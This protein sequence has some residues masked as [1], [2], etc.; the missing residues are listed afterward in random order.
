MIT[1]SGDVRLLDFGT[2]S[3]SVRQAAPHE[4]AHGNAQRGSTALTPA[5]AS[6]ELLEG[7]P[8]DP[9]DDLFA[10]ACLTYELLTGKH[11]FGQ[12]R[13]T[14]ARNLR[15]AVVRPSGLSQKQWNTLELGL[16]WSRTDRSMSISDW[17]AALNEEPAIQGVVTGAPA[18]PAVPPVSGAAAARSVPAAPAVPSVGATPTALRARARPAER[19]ISSRLVAGIALLVICLVAWSVH[20][21]SRNGARTHDGGPVAAQPSPPVD[22]PTLMPIAAITTTSSA[23]P[24]PE[25][26][27]VPAAAPLA[28]QM[29]LPNATPT[30]VPVAAAAATSGAPRPAEAAAP[31]AP[32][33]PR[34]LTAAAAARAA[35]R[36]MAP[37]NGVPQIS[38]TARAYRVRAGGHFAEVHVR[39]SAS[40]GGDASFDWWTEPSSA[41]ADEDYFS[42]GRTTQIF[43]AG[44]KSASLFIRVMPNAARK[45]PRVF[46][47]VIGSPSAGAV[48]G[49]RSRARIVL[50]PPA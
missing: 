41:N 4:G 9:R 32:P 33:A 26:N 16:A 15:V 42:Q 29:V 18:P 50:L 30:A 45:A 37:H 49:R 19:R 14:E 12:Y 25:Q 48:L 3:V 28:P 20:D 35:G 21:R 47:V 2:S 11:P 17:V 38:F 36:D 44:H 1:H 31:P 6:C 43:A 34:A 40:S 22:A 10:F 8:A 13:S 24:A 7:L 39:R 23:A 27:A 5:Y 46:Y